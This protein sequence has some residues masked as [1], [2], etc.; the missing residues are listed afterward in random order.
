MAGCKEGLIDIIKTALHL[1]NTAT[2]TV[3]TKILE[4]TE[5]P[6]PAGTRPTDDVSTLEDTSKINVAAGL[7]DEGKLAMKGLQISGS[8]QQKELYALWRSGECRP[9]KIVLSDTAAT[10]IQFCATITGWSPNNG[11][12][13]KNR[14]DFELTISGEVSYSDVDGPFI[15]VV[16]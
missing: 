12:G 16:P 1:G 14:L 2:P 15:P 11:A 5:V 8:E 3:Y 6:L 13:K 10:T 9:Y 4:L 7:I